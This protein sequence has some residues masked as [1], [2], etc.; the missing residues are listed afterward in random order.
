MKSDLPESTGWT[1]EAS[2]VTN[3]STSLNANADIPLCNGLITQ[4]MVHIEVTYCRWCDS[5]MSKN[6]KKTNVLLIYYSV[7]KFKDVQTTKVDCHV[8]FRAGLLF[9]ISYK[10]NKCNISEALQHRIQYILYRATISVLFQ[11]VGK[12]IVPFSRLDPLKYMCS[13]AVVCN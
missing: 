4:F 10:I 3:T 2:S 13:S 1:D 6:A 8:F 5:K 7:R 12:S 11:F 9:I